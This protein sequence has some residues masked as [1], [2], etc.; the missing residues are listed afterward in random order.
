MNQISAKTERPIVYLF[1]GWNKNN[2][3]ISY[4]SWWTT[5]TVERGRLS[6]HAPLLSNHTDGRIN[7]QLIDNSSLR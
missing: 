2:F 6:A 5:T 4:I 7:S 3:D 1:D